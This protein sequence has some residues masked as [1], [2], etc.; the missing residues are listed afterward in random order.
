MTVAE[1]LIRYEKEIMPTKKLRRRCVRLVGS[2][3]INGGAAFIAYMGAGS[4]MVAKASLALVLAF[5]QLAIACAIFPAIRKIFDAF[6][7]TVLNRI[8]TVVVITA[9]MG[10]ILNIFNGISQVSGDYCP[11]C[12]KAIL[13]ADESHRIMDLQLAFHKEVNLST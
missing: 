2:I 11:A 4:I 6:M 5:S 9:V 13:N 1:A 10:L 7:T 8:L 12:N 3:L